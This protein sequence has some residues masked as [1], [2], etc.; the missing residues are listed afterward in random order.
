[1][2]E[3]IGFKDYLL[4]EVNMDVDLNDPNDATLQ[5]KRAARLAK[6]SPQ[7]LGRQEQEKARAGVAAAKA[8]EGPTAAIKQQ[9]A[10]LQQRLA[11][12]QMKLASM[13][14]TSGEIQ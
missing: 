6:T 9:I 14:K 13:Q 3:D 1:M 10:M 8:E 11:Q 5:I 7:R 12:L 2:Q 4:N